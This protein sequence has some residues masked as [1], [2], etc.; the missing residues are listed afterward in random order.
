MS[1]PN[2]WFPAALDRRV[3]SSRN[4]LR[5]RRGGSSRDLGFARLPEPRGSP[6]RVAAEAFHR[7]CLRVEA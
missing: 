7:G 3:Q 5:N 2:R 1:R 4:R 6:L